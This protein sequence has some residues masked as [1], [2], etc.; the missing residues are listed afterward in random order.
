MAQEI[1]K[2]KMKAKT[3]EQYDVTMISIAAHE[4]PNIQNQGKSHILQ[5]VNLLHSM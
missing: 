5:G 1:K 2:N 4:L 3:D